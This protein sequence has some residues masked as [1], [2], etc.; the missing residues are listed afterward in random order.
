MPRIQE[1]GKGKKRN[2][3]K[4]GRNQSE[5]RS[6]KGKKRGQK[7]EKGEKKGKIGGKG[8]YFP[9]SSEEWY[10][11]FP[12][13][14]KGRAKNMISPKNIIKIHQSLYNIHGEEESDI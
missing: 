2:K 11:Y 3:E 6:E 14:L 4:K 5:N 1:K 12:Q 8:Y 9:F 10:Y 7:K 13:L